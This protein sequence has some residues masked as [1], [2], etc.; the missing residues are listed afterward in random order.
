MVMW[1]VAVSL[2]C[3]DLTEATL[4]GAGLS[5]LAAFIMV[6]LLIMVSWPPLAS[7][8]CGPG[9]SCHASQGRHQLRMPLS[10]G[11]TSGAAPTISC[12]WG[13]FLKHTSS[14]I[15]RLL[16]STRLHSHHPGEPLYA[17][18]P[19]VQPAVGFAA[20]LQHLRPSSAGC[21]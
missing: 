4:H 6:F 18:A 2:L 20:V 9:R 1:F 8:A 14:C 17:G 5:V 13:A 3:R 16:P 15:T 7:S 11:S 12:C 19:G 10:D 21:H